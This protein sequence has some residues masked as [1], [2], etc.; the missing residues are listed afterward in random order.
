MPAERISAEPLKRVYLDRGEQDRP[1]GLGPAG[2]CVC[3]VLLVVATDEDPTCGCSEWG[4]LCAVCASNWVRWV[5]CAKHEG[6]P[7]PTWANQE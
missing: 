5:P 3:Q 2:D 6:Q 7:L 4:S 1:D